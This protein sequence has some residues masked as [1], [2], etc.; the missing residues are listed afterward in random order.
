MNLDPLCTRSNASDGDRLQVNL[1][2][3]D[4]EVFIYTLTIMFTF[5][6]L[7]MLFCRNTLDVNFCDQYQCFV[8]VAEC[9][10]QQRGVCVTFAYFPHCVSNIKATRVHAARSDTVLV[11]HVAFCTGVAISVNMTLLKPA[12]SA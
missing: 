10:C 7:V 2:N 12:N 9:L 6:S 1:M 3:G 5:R 4:F 11:K 8:Q